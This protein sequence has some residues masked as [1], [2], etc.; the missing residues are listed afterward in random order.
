MALS[1]VAVKLGPWG[2][3]SGKPC[4]IN[5]FSRPQRLVSMS[6][7]SN[8]T[9]GGCINGFSFTYI[10]QKDEP[11]NVDLG[12]GYR[13]PCSAANMLF[14]KKLIPMSIEWYRGGV[15]TIKLR[16][17]EFLS[18]VKGT[19]NGTGVTS[20]T[21]VTSRKTIGPYGWPSGP[22]F[23][24]PLQHGLPHGGGVVAF[25][26]NFEDNL[27]ALGVYVVADRLKRLNYYRR[28]ILVGPW[29]PLFEPSKYWKLRGS[30]AQLHSITVRS[31][32][33]S[34]GRVY[35][36]AYTCLGKDGETMSMD[37]DESNTKGLKRVFAMNKDNYIT[38]I[39]GTYDEYGITSLK[40]FSTQDVYGPFGCTIGT[41]F[42]VSLQENA[43]AV[44]FFGYSSPHSLLSFGADVIPQED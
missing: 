21:M 14:P 41:P 39:G 44:S 43:A 3:P 23:S 36:F 18:H 40:F 31:S 22:E 9:P 16:D 19:A 29:G 30:P 37:S 8:E 42:S 12:G 34:G 11:I 24:L 5:S 17:E 15:K 4:D 32:E 27:K 38:F 25:F 33:R 28:N 10:D 13:A 26:G 1:S 35:G 6:I 20:L 7:W 2:A